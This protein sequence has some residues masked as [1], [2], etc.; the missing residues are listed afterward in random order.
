MPGIDKSR[1]FVPLKIAVLTVSDTRD[2]ADTSGKYAGRAHPRRRPYARRALDRQGRGQ[3][4]PSAREGLDRGQIHRR[5]DHHRRHRLHRPRRDAGGGRAAVR[6][7]DGRLCDHVPSGEREKD[8]YLGDPE[9]APPPALPTR[10]LFSACPVRPA[11]A[12]TPGTRSWCTSSMSRYRPCNFVEI[13]P[14]LDEHLRR[15]KAKGATD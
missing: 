5:G 1:Q 7:E 6:K 9:R 12:R 8:R 14:R 4:D 10:P 2:R 11:P 15:G 3:G 13:L